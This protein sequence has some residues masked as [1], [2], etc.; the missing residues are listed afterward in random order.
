[1]LSASPHCPIGEV[2][3]ASDLHL[4]MCNPHRYRSVSPALH[5]PLPEAA[6]AHGIQDWVPSSWTLQLKTRL[7]SVRYH[8]LRQ[9]AEGLWC[10][11][12][13]EMFVFF[14]IPDLNFL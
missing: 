6:P 1:M 8:F 2:F 7:K 14:T 13:K 11:R 4:R 5:Q 3:H 10:H 12:L 9:F